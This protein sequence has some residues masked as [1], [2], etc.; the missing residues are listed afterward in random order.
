MTD[1]QESRAVEPY[2]VWDISAWPVISQEDGGLDQKDWVVRPGE[3]SREGKEHWWL[4]KPVK[5]ASYRRYDDWSERLAAEFA[6]LLQLPA[7]DIELAHGRTTEGIVSRNVTPTG[8]SMESGNTLLS[9]FDGY[10]DCAGDNRPRNRIGH[11]L[12]NIAELLAGCS[13]PPGSTCHHWTGLEVFAGYLVFDAWIANTDRHAINWGV[14][15]SE[16]DDRRALAA[17]FDHGSALASGT[18]DAKLSST[19]AESYAR[20]GNASRFENGHEMTLVDVALDAVRL[21]GG[22]AAGRTGG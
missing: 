1:G 8:W 4:Y 20:R 21:A 5:P 19:T 18:Q 2:A 7:A 9:E 17:S 3:V 6:R 22:R 10:L 11:N 13:G 15:L 12:T 16:N 14:L